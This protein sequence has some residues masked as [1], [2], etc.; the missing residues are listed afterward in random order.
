MLSLTRI[1]DRGTTLLLSLIL[2]QKLGAAGLGVYST[3]LALYAVIAAAGEA[4]ATLFLIRE[5]AKDRSL[6]ASYIVHLSLMALGV[7]LVLT[8]GSEAV[9]HNIG[10]AQGVQNAVALVLLAILPKTLNSIQESVFIVYGRTEFEMIATFVSSAAYLV[11]SFVL[12]ENGYG[13]VSIVAVYVALEYLV[14]IIYYVM[15]VRAI[16]PLNF[17]FDTRLAGRLVREIKTFAGSSALGALF[18]RPEIIILSVMSTPQEVGYYS[19]AVRISEVW[20]FV[21][22]VFLNNVFPVLTR[23]YQTSRQRFAEVQSKAIRYCLAYSGPLTAGLF[24]IAGSIIL[25]LFGDDFEPSVTNLRL[26]AVNLTLFT[27]SA[28]F[29]RSV[30]ATGRQDIVLRSQLITIIVRLISAVALIAVW[31]SHGAA[32]AAVI[33]TAIQVM[34]LERAVHKAGIASSIIASSWRIGLASVMVGAVSWLLDHWT[35]LWVVV[36]AGAV[37]YV[38]AI[39]LLRAIPAEDLQRLN[40]S[41]PALARARARLAASAK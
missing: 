7:S 13:V 32:L 38:V 34:L 5:L 24:A 18:A 9:I 11:I 22:Q 37:T 6:T 3:A 36:P 19:A 35:T 16:T 10:Y 23:S 25:S 20:L 12:L 28:L 17:A 33:G 29:W 39:V 27:L 41:I 21:P 8:V 1:V 40:R 30:S 14:T 26:L 15:I 31:A 4:G 2:A